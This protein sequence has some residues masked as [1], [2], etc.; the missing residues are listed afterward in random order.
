MRNFLIIFICSVGLVSCKSSVPRD[1]VEIGN[2]KFTVEVVEDTETR[3]Q[4]LMFREKLLL[5][6]GMFFVFEQEKFHR[7]WMKNTSIPLDII[8]ISK[9]Q[10]VVDVQTVKPCKT[11][12]CP[13]YVPLGMAKY[14][15]EVNAKSFKGRVGDAVCLKIDN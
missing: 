4:G 11:K 14:V 9:D 10:K 6:H 1:F 15:L 3:A 5:N 13:S 2:Q 8:W 7:F 12:T